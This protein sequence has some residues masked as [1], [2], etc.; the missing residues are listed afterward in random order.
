MKLRRK[1]I[2]RPFPAETITITVTE[3]GVK[4]FVWEGMSEEVK[5]ITENTKLL[6]FD[7]IQERLAEQIFYWYSGCTAGQPVDDPTQ[8][9]YRVTDAKLGYT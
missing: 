3:S 8:F 5:R 9:Q 4:S 7:K 6:P 2:R 1:C